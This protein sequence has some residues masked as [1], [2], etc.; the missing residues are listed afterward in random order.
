MTLERRALQ[1][2]PRVSLDAQGA[3]EA[4]RQ[5]ADEASTTP[6]ATRT[7]SSPRFRVSDPAVRDEVV[8]IGAHLD[9]WHTGNGATD[10]ADGAATMIEAMRILK[11]VGARPRRT[12]RVAL[13]AARNRGFS[14]RRPGS[15]QHLMGDAN[16]RGTRR[17][18]T[19]TSTSTTATGRSTA[20]T[21]EQRRGPADFRAWLEPLKASARGGTSL[22]ASAQP[23]I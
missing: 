11:A 15:T 22:K 2:D 3:G 19:S 1:H 16:Q 14:D 4:S 18:S 7:T 9:S 20:S 23:I 12:I 21:A 5:R 17:S 10:N 6:T 13:W 8:M